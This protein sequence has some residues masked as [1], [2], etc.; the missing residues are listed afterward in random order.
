VICDDVRLARNG[1]QVELSARV[2]REGAEPFRLWY[3]FPAKYGRAI[4]TDGSP[5]VAA[6]MMVCMALGET[7]RIDAPV[8][9]QLLRASESLMEVLHRWWPQ[10]AVIPIEAPVRRTVRSGFRRR[11]AATFFTLG[12]DSYY[13][14]LKNA[15]GGVWGTPPIGA[16]LF[17]NGFDVRL[18]NAELLAEVDTNLRRAARATGTEVIAID[19]NLRDLTDPLVLW[20]HYHG[21][22]LASVGLALENMFEAIY[23][24]ASCSCDDLFAW[25]SHPM[26][27]PLWSTE[28]TR[29][30]HDGCE[31]RR[32]QKVAR[33]ADVPVVQAT[34]RS[35]WENRDNHYNCGVCEKC[36]R[37][38]GLLVAAGALE[39]METFPHDYPLEA[40]ADID[41]SDHRVATRFGKVL[42]AL[43]DDE[44]CRPLREALLRYTVPFESRD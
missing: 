11:P 4:R 9:S 40:L 5:F 34:L 26:I 44:R 10:L 2:R 33:I 41:W 12:V 43:P 22:A 7:L 29:F 23:V 25:G 32:G 37:T 3:R 19:T 36:L 1:S 42:D 14:L 13:T 39:W 17:V 31:L 21:S 38:M 27:D 8:S 28:K 18:H 30:I 20:T 6:L 16:L 24:A 35:C 15:D